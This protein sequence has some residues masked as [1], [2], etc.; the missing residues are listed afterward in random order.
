M[1]KMSKVDK[2]FDIETA[3]NIR[4]KYRT[5]C[6]GAWVYTNETD[7]KLFQAYEFDLFLEFNEKRTFLKWDAAYVAW[8]NENQAAE[9]AQALN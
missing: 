5:K 3:L 4:V 9:I 8:Y 2:D 1:G 6:G 7:V